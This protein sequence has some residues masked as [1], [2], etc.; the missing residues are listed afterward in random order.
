LEI[1]LQQEKKFL[2]ALFL[3]LI[4]ITIQQ[5][6]SDDNF[7][8]DGLGGMGYSHRSYKKTI[9]NYRFI[10]GRFQIGIFKK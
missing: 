6:S 4:C 5:N 2:H 7:F 3:F 10:R 9:P 8:R 1:Q